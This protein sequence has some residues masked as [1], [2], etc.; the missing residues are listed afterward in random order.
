MI[1]PIKTMTFRLSYRADVEAAKSQQPW[2]FAAKFGGD[3]LT[4]PLCFVRVCGR[5]LRPERS[6]L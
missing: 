6:L 5:G 1:L 4:P 3:S 2:R